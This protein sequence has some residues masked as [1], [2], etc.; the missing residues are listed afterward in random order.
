MAALGIGYFW[1]P[2]ALRHESPTRVT[3]FLALNPITAA[4][5]GSVLLDEAPGLAPASAIALIGAGL[6]LATRQQAAPK[7]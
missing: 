2:Y 5:L 7:G 3:G 6:W 4:V 1:W